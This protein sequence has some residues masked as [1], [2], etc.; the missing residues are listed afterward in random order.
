[1]EQSLGGVLRASYPE[2]GH[3]AGTASSEDAQAVESLR[4]LL[5]RIS[6]TTAVV[7]SLRDRVQV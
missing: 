4:S 1:L 2:E 3:A 6:Q 7:I 5:T